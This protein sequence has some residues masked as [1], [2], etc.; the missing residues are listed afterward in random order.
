MFKKTTPDGPETGDAIPPLGQNMHV[1][2]RSVSVIGPTLIFKGELSANEYLVIEGH[3]EGTVAHQ[4]KNLTVGKEG[5]VHANIRA[6]V[7]EIQGEVTGDIRGDQIVKL[8]KTA[9]VN[10]NIQSRRL[11]MEDGAFF[12]GSIAMDQQ[13]EK[14]EQPPVVVAEK[15]AK[16]SSVG[17]G[18]A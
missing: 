6:E 16:V 4:G 15:P 10:G 14:K 17:S 2:T 9:V 18:S 8:T 3:I 1:R 11:I 5:R 7:V 13:Q 12:S